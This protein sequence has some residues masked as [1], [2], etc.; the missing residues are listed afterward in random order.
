MRRPSLG[1]VA[2]GAV[3]VGSIALLLQVSGPYLEGKLFPVFRTFEVVSTSQVEGGTAIAVKFDKLRQCASRGFAWYYLPTGR[4]LVV[5]VS[6]FAS[7]NRPVGED[8]TS[9]E[10]VLN[11]T[12][13]DLLS[14]KVAG[15]TFSQ[16]HPFWVT[17]TE[18]YP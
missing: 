3:I 9:N 15:V 14:G 18:V 16:C 8:Q 4:E 2:L 12:P 10:F 6:G 13:A 7:T 5:K 11:I 1:S 17:R